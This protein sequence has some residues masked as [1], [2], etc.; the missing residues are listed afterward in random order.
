MIQNNRF[1]I[2][3]VLLH[4]LILSGIIAGPLSKKKDKYPNGPQKDWNQRQFAKYYRSIERYSNKTADL[5]D[6][7]LRRQDAIIS[8]NKISTQIWNYGSIS[9]PGNRVTDIIWEGLGYGYEFGPFICAEVPLLSKGH[10]DAY[11]KIENGDT[12][13]YARV[14]SED[15]LQILKGHQMD[16]NIGPGNH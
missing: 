10:P 9:E 13:W 12:T 8:G 6:Q 15:L 7:I 14:I 1:L 11:P 2:I 16:Q 5:D 4:G 3:I